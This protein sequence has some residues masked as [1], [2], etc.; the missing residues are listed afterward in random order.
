[1]IHC[2]YALI[3]SWLDLIMGKYQWKVKHI[4]IKTGQE[5]GNRRCKKGNILKG[6]GSINSPNR[7]FPQ[8]GIH[9]FITA[10]SSHISVC[11][12]S[13][14]SAEYYLVTIIY[15]CVTFCLSPG[16]IM[17]IL[18]SYM[19]FVLSP[20]HYKTPPLRNL[21]LKLCHVYVPEWRPRQ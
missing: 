19:T 5:V 15:S 11:Q 21:C 6:A 14:R 13:P 12:F 10:Y 17:L 16:F 1:M 18:T 8:R 20:T 2:K 3:P 9:V 7:A 4:L